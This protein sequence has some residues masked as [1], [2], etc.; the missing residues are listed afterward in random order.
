M[1]DRIKLPLTF[2]TIMLKHDLEHIENVAWINH[3]VQ[4]NYTGTWSAIPLRSPAGA[5]H[6][7]MM[8]YSDP[9]CTEF[10]DTP[11][12]KDCLYFQ[13][14]LRSFQCPLQA[15]RLM[16]LTP[17]SLIKEHRDH[18]LA[19]ELGAVR[20]HIP[21]YTNPDVHFILNDERVILD[22]GE[23]WYL[24]LA[25]PHSLENCGQTDRVHIVIDAVVNDWLR[26]LLAEGK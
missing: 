17:S 10:E 15:V 22:E 5:Q 19:V 20:L 16:K 9:A 4:Q 23:C 14:V 1:K 25:N 18:G 13:K 3:F 7:V 6:P 12:L 21:I 11:F 26:D 2:D 8:I 24:R